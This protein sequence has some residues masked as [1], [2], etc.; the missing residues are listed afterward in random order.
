[1]R[2]A[3]LVAV[4]LLCFLVT[5][6]AQKEQECNDDYEDQK[7]NKENDECAGFKEVCIVDV[8]DPSVDLI[9][10]FKRFHSF[11]TGRGDHDLVDSP[12]VFIGGVFEKELE[13]NA[14]VAA[15]GKGKGVD[16]IRLQCTGTE[17]IAEIETFR[18]L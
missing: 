5:S 4:F 7:Q 13:G 18:L 8:S 3:A 11:R 9:G 1:M 16:P 14:K 12:A 10:A 6:D 15:C 2:R 17:Q